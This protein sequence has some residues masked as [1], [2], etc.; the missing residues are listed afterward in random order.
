MVEKKK[1]RY[2]PKTAADVVA[3][4]DDKVAADEAALAE[5]E[6]VVAGAYADY[7]E[8]LKNYEARSDVETLEARRAREAGTSFSDAAFRRDADVADEGL[9]TTKATQPETEDGSKAG[10]DSKETEKKAPK[11]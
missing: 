10:S 3:P 9:V 1:V 11:K 2:N 6:G 7:E 8:A 4:H 5:Q